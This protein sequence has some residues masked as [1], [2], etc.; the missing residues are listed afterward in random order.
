MTELTQPVP[1]TQRLKAYLKTNPRIKAWVHWALFPAHEY[2]PRWWVRT[3]VN[4]FRHKRGRASLI[5]WSARLDVLPYNRFELGAYS[6]IESHS[7]INNAVG[8]VLI[9]D[10]TLIGVSNTL[11]GPLTIGHHVL[12][13]QHVVLSGLN[14]AYE[15]VT[16]PISQQPTT[17]S[18]IVV[19]DG[20]WIGANSVVTAGV[21]IGRNSVVAGGSVVT[22]DVPPFSVVG[23][24]PARLLKQYNPDTQQWERVPAR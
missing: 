13:A 1:I 22:R 16:R 5:R 6:T 18:P 17:T 4:P 11:L 23:G 9:G 3:F 15:D 8:D 12:L 20:V 24:N 7:T 14:H 10:H 21:R 19:E 2:R